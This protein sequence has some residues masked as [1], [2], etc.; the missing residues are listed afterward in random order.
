MLSTF[1]MDYFSDAFSCSTAR[2]EHVCT[3]ISLLTSIISV[4]FL[5]QIIFKIL[6]T[7]RGLLCHLHWILL[8]LPVVFGQGQFFAG[9]DIRDISTFVFWF[10]YLYPTR[11]WVFHRLWSRVHCPS[12]ACCC[13]SAHILYLLFVFSFTF[14]AFFILLLLYHFGCSLCSSVIS[15]IRICFSTRS[16]LH[17]TRSVL[18]FRSIGPCYT[19]C[20]W[21]LLL[22]WGVQ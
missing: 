17:N 11:V 12:C 1:S 2:I 13:S 6:S 14:C 10:W 16:A 4:S 18:I 8:A 9:P 21:S 20:K 22:L 5:A 3:M 15:L 7:L 19:Q